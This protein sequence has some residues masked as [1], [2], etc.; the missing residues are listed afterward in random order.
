MAR[1]IV[2]AHLS[3]RGSEGLRIRNCTDFLADAA[4]NAA[5]GIR[6]IREKAHSSI[7]PADAAKNAAWGMGLNVTSIRH[8]QTDNG[9]S[10]TIVP[11]RGKAHPGISRADAA[12]NAAWGML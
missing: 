2:Q 1:G 11:I 6:L 3:I 8:V 7:S 10:G 9:A 5:G 12:K 4:K